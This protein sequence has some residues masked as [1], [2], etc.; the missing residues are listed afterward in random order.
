MV[1]EKR[2]EKLRADITA[3][4]LMN[5][6]EKGDWLNLLELMND[7]QIGELEEILKVAPPTASEGPTL[8]EQPSPPTPP[9][10]TPVPP[11]APLVPQLSHISNLPSA[12]SYEKPDSFKP[13]PISKAVAPRP[14][15]APV[16]TSSGKYVPP[17]ATPPLV[18]QMPKGSL[19]NLSKPV[20]DSMAKAAATQIFKP[21][22]PPKPERSTPHLA[23]VKTV[24]VKARQEPLRLDSMDDV[25]NLDLT[26]F[27]SYDHS[28]LIPKFVALVRQYGYFNVL[29][30]FEASKLYK[31][32]LSKGKSM[33]AGESTEQ[34]FTVKVEEFEQIVD[35]LLAIRIN[36]Q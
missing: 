31:S 33:L 7:K 30:A 4:K 17:K 11:A 21:V 8:T 3:S 25:A 26:K 16:H 27:R 20:K 14:A 34:K 10:K 5:D 35:L 28:D 9:V 13:A 23:P 6:R 36:R 15:P 1:T 29:Q 12:V 22:V 24:P 2:L 19:V 32:Y 18:P